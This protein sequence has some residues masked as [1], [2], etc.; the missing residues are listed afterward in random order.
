MN[1]VDQIEK[2]LGREI[3]TSFK[4]NNYKKSFYCLA[5]Q[6]NSIFLLRG[7][8]VLFEVENLEDYFKAKKIIEDNEE[9]IS[10][11]E[12]ILMEKML[13]E[14]P[15]SFILKKEKSVF[16]KGAI[17][18][19]SV[20]T[21][22]ENGQDLFRLK[23]SKRILEKGIPLNL[24]SLNGNGIYKFSGNRYNDF[25]EIWEEIKQSE[26]KFSSERIKEFKF[27]KDLKI[28]FFNML[29]GTSK[30]KKFKTIFLNSSDLLFEKY[31]HSN[32]E[33][34][35]FY[36]FKEEPLNL[37]NFHEMMRL[38]KAACELAIDFTESSIS[39]FEDNHYFY[40][41]ISEKIYIIS[42]N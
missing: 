8:E 29:F 26:L 16:Y 18:N 15:G 25:E 7:L 11:F 4:N 3:T 22:M 27:E 17:F 20:K 1:L 31:L 6:D 37:K 41:N 33:E 42:K 2:D 13:I 36:F 10:S 28:L 40:I 38:R 19:I 12:E 14:F 30:L 23:F 32:F 9:L 21:R 24:T 35:I 5:K 39:A 34:M